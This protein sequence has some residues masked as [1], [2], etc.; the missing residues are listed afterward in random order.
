MNWPVFFL[1]T[2]TIFGTLF[3]CK[4][5]TTWAGDDDQNT[6]VWIWLFAADAII[7]S[8]ALGWLKG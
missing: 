2:T 7:W 3:F 4:W 5:F 6:R 1:S 8:A